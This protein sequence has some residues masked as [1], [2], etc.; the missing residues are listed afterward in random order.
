MPPLDTQAIARPLLFSLLALI[1][2]AGLTL[3]TELS[4]WVCGYAAA[5]ILLRILILFRTPAAPSRWLLVPLTLIGILIVLIQYRTLFGRDAG[6]SLL[7]VMLALK[8][9]ESRTQRDFYLAIFLGFFFIV[10]QFLFHQSMEV[11]AYLML[12]SLGLLSL[13]AEINQV[14]Q[15]FTPR[16]SLRLGLTVML[17]A[18]PIT[19]VLFYLFPRL[20]APLWGFM[21]DRQGATTGFSDRLSPGS[22]NRLG[23]SDEIAFRVDFQDP[24]PP[25]QQR[26]WRGQVFWLIDGKEWRT[27]ESKQSRSIR[28][29]ASPGPPI[30][31]T[32]T[33]E[34]H[35]QRW[36]FP[37]D[38][39]AEVPN[40]TLIRED[41]Q[42]LA[43][44]PLT[45]RQTY[46]LSSH[47]LYAISSLSPRE[48]EWGLQ[49]PANVTPRMRQLA[50]RWANS[51]R[52]TREVVDLAL[53]HIR[54]EDFIYTLK[55]PLL[56]DNP[57]DEFLFETR[58]GFCEHFATSF[59]V[60]MRLA[61]IPSRV[62][63]GYQG[64]EYNPLG[65][66]YLIRQSDAHAWAEVWLAER[67][68]VRVDPTGAVA[69]ER[70]ERA[71]D[72]SNL[73]EGLPAQFLFANQGWIRTIFK[74]SRFLLDA[75][76]MG[77]YMW[78]INY[79]SD[80]QMD[81]LARLGLGFIRPSGLGIL[82]VVII[83]SLLGMISLSL[84]RQGR[85]PQDPLQQLYD[86][87]CRRL[88]KRGLGR[89][90]YEGPRSFADKVIRLRPDLRPQ[91]EA[92]TAIYIESRYG[93]GGDSQA[94]RR[95]RRLLWR[96][97]P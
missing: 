8:L 15:G 4:L 53:D 51:G 19:L 72:L 90:S 3:I 37:L 24:A 59:V 74:H 38:L 91:V 54:R 16:Q 95:L 21:T 89:L 76:N 12:I 28:E 17:Q 47:P 61:G 64:G 57:T 52:T 34:P 78:V 2:L 60:M 49:L 44:K 62:V 96:F 83:G 84:L 30:R 23:L 32:L 10:C 33:I 66:Y 70:I 55:P 77:W 22:V 93:P 39:P 14:G 80:R 31:Y 58:K 7:S 25:P 92:I 71:L 75:A 85:R 27:P 79:T 50:T 6:V 67:G 26:Y 45:S 41:F 48:R 87:Y 56:G 81:L 86:R 94:L 43:E 18:L 42:L 36:L 5:V 20:A 88:A 40:S 46:R 65:G 29:Y 69:P 1:L 11:A 9:L 73:R 13:L 68:W 63:T 82:L 97:R 35:R